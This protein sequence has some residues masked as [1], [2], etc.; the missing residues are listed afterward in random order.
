[1][2]SICSSLLALALIL[3]PFPAWSQVVG[4]IYPSDA[5]AS[6][7]ALPS[8]AIGS[9]PAPLS[10]PALSAVLTPSAAGFSAA[11]AALPA[12]LDAQPAA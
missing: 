9:A 10:A 7:L 11:P 12:P 6:R 2:K 4:A 1:M 8:N 5:A 3:S